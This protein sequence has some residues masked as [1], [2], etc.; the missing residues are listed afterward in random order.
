M[1]LYGIL[2]AFDVTFAD[3]GFEEIVVGVVERNVDAAAVRDA[4]H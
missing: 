3:Q 4:A 1:L 2:A